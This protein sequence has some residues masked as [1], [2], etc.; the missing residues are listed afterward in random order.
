M[1]VCDA[2]SIRGQNCIVHI[3][4]VSVHM[5]MYVFVDTLPLELLV[6]VCGNELLQTLQINV[7]TNVICIWFVS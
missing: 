2:P 5:Y 4:A 1:C 3:F 6:A 7:K